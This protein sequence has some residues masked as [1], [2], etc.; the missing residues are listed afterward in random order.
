[1]GF[2][3]EHQLSLIFGLL[4]NI[5]SFLVFMAPIPT[6]YKICKKKSS[7]GFQSIPY[8]ISLLSA[9][10]LLYYGFLKTNA[11]LIITINGIGCVIE[12]IYLTLYIIYAPKKEKLFTVRLVI[13]NI[14]AFG[15]I[16][17]TTIFLLKGSKRVN[18][19]GWICAVYNLAVFAAPLS[20]MMRVIRTKSVE[21]M[22][23]TLS[24]FLT[25][26]ATVWFFYGYFVRDFFIALP[27]VMGFLFGI[28]QMIL[29]IIYKDAANKD[30]EANMK[31]QESNA[32]IK[33]SSFN[34]SKFYPQA[35]QPET[36]SH[37][38]LFT[39]KSCNV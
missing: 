2:L 35:D 34:N 18:A 27:N 26:C 39:A 36:I 14:G 28:S 37:N 21:F 31:Q 20:I 4:G 25:L 22:P 15:L 5:V 1:M 12:V 8:V 30:V 11:Y 3:T 33:L 17:V 9:M 13:S 38:C 29:Y 19:I 32:E 24:L 10:L 23:F 7:E 16:M 6:F